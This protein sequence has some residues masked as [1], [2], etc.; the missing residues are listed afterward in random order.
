MAGHSITLIGAGHMGMALAGGWLRVPGGPALIISDPQPT[1]AVR[2]WAETGR[3][4]L[5]PDPAPADILVIAVKPQVYGAISQSLRDWAGPDTLVLS[6]MAGIGMD[7]LATDLGTA[8]ILRAMPNMPGLIGQGVTL[9]AAPPGARDKDM[10]T[11]RQLL[12]PLGSVEGPLP[13]DRLAAGMAISSC[14]PAYVFLLAEVMAAAGEAEGL[15]AGMA[16][17]IARRAVEGAAALM[18]ASDETPREL[19]RAVTSPGGTTRAALDVLMAEN[20]IP[21]LMDK[22]VKAVIRRDRE[23]A[24]GNRK[25]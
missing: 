3:V 17:R 13:E 9:L 16:A 4:R 8:R 12:E 23:L 6:V 1:G 24:D 14:S 22:A 7:T 19:R 25:N 18:A 2:D 20:G 15:E 5:N 11:A 10:E 21:S